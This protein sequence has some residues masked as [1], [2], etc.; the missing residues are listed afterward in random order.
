MRLDLDI[1]LPRRCIVCDEALDAREEC[2]CTSCQSFLPYVDFASCDDNDP[3]RLLWGDLPFV[4]GGALMHYNPASPFHRIIEGMK[5][6]GRPDV[7]VAIGK[8]LAQSIPDAS[9]FDG[10]D[11]VVPVPLSSQRFM[12]RGYNQAEQIAKG[13]S[14]VSG[15]PLCTSLLKRKV[16]NATQTRLNSTLRAENVQ[17]IFEYNASEKCA[18]RHLLLVD[19]VITTGA[20]ILSVARTLSA[21]IPELRFSVACVGVTEKR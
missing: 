4:K 10:I 19:D 17:D 2:L 18:F 14:E 6:R 12:K 21:S 5:Y 20:T 8:L 13:I 7:C 9:F 16:D 1:L 15:V 3:L 11:A